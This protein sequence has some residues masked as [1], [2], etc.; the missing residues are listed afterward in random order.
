[1][2]TVQFVA[3]NLKEINTEDTIKK[4]QYGLC[5]KVLAGFEKYFCPQHFQHCSCFIVLIL[6]SGLLCYSVK[7]VWPGGKSMI[8][9]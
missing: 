4:N 1:M 5:S 2:Y 8:Y 9:L 7:F 3:F 6:P